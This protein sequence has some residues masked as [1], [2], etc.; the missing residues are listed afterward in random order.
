[1]SYLNLLLSIFIFLFFSLD[2]IFFSVSVN[3][4]ILNYRSEPPKGWIKLNLASNIESIE[5]IIY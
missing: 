1:M 3:G 2:Y 4:G 5:F